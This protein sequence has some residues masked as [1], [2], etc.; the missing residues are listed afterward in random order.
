MLKSVSKMAA[1]VKS[2]RG[3]GLRLL[4]SFSLAFVCALAGILTS[5]Q[6]ED[7]SGT[8]NIAP[9]T[10][11][12]TNYNFVGNAGTVNVSTT[13][14][15]VYL[16]GT[17]TTAAGGSGTINVTGNKGQGNTGP[18]LW[19]YK[20]FS[21]F[22]GTVTIGNAASSQL[23]RDWIDFHLVLELLLEQPVLISNQIF[24]NIYQILSLSML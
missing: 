7:V 18:A 5:A 1:F 15:H 2:G 16:R 4:G 6:A 21:G 8:V 13:N 23:A 22:S 3:H 14:A 19:L 17:F 24:Q 11:N 12:S 20:D 10:D 9:G